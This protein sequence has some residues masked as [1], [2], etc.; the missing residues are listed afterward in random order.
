MIV[1]FPSAVSL[2]LRGAVEQS[3]RL[4]SDKSRDAPHAWQ[5]AAS[6]VDIIEKKAAQ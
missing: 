2:A 3:M 4:R 6:G 1:D 5:H